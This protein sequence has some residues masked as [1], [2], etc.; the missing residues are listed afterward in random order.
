MDVRIEPDNRP[1]HVRIKVLADMY[2]AQAI[3]LEK[4]AHG[5]TSAAVVARRNASWL[6][7]AVTKLEGE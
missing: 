5:I 3:G 2:T 1:L 4:Q 7:E 6:N